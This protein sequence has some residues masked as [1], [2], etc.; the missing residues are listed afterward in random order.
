MGAGAGGGVVKVS[1]S[2]GTACKTQRHV[3]KLDMCE[4]GVA[5]PQESTGNQVR[6]HAKLCELTSG[7][8][9]QLLRG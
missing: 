1:G 4:N 7:A 3:L 2:E 5:S 8:R 6:G 9:E